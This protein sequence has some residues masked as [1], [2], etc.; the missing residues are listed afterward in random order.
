VAA[1]W[2][3]VCSFLDSALKRSVDAIGAGLLL[4]VFAPFILMVAVAIKADSRGPVLYRCRRVGS[5]GREFWMLKFRKMHDRATGPALTVTEDTRLTR[6]GRFLARSKIDEI[7]QLWNVLRGQMSLVGPRPED[8]GFVQ[9]RR[10]DFE[11]ILQVKP[12]ITGL[13]QLAF[14]RESDLL[15]PADRLGDYLQRFLPQK[16]ALDRMYVARRT[17]WSDLS[18]LAWTVTAIPLR[19]EVAV[20][21]QTIKLTVR[22]RRAASELVPHPAPLTI[23]ERSAPL[24]DAF[25]H[26]AS[27]SSEPTRSW[28]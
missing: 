14:A 6:V 2:E 3:H 23:S 11:V 9:L 18:I 1:D 13:S 16:I 12:G 15:D 26:P 28:N 21:R 4:V 22:R 10:E 19:R 24:G 20:N 5:R 27:T 17:I 7:P 25:L 8:P